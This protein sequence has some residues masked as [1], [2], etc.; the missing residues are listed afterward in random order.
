MV[1]VGGECGHAICCF[2]GGCL[3]CGHFPI[4]R[5]LPSGPSL[6]PWS[7]LSGCRPGAASPVCK[8]D[9]IFGGGVRVLRFGVASKPFP[10]MIARVVFVEAVADELH[11]VLWC[12]A[13]ATEVQVMRV[14]VADVGGDVINIWYCHECSPIF[15]EYAE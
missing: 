7:R 1:T 8:Y 4:L 10:A 14:L 15:T 3:P 9:P 11:F 6:I 13:C 2:A 5:M 12:V